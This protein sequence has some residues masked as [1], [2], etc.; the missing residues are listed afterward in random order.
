MKKIF[1]ISCLIL[2]CVI[3]FFAERHALKNHSKPSFDI[4]AITSIFPSDSRWAFPNEP[5]V[6]AY[7]KQKYT[8]L[9]GG[10]QCYAFISED[11]C[12]VLKFFKQDK[13]AKKEKSKVKGV[14]AR[15]AFLTSQK[16]A[17][18]DLKEETGLLYLHFVPRDGFDSQVTLIDH[19]NDV[20]TLELGDFEFL[21]QKRAVMITDVISAHMQKCEEDAGKKIIDEVFCFFRQR[22][23]KGIVDYD[24]QIMGNLGL[25][26]GRI[27]QIDTG[28]FAIAKTS[29][30]LKKD[31]AQFYSKNKDFR[32]WLQER[33]PT[34]YEYFLEQTAKFERYHQ[35]LC[36][37]V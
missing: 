15:K 8:Y 36:L 7:L 37:R 26:E 35:S 10:G 25:L 21:L 22:L 9:A 27:V 19:N 16:I 30:D 5:G 28:R 33:Y 34:L 17:Y 31:L 4:P 14:E 1:G 13:F 3:C 6:Q 32:I 12:Y 2:I 18:E 24:P 29:K 23:E 11:G 20:H